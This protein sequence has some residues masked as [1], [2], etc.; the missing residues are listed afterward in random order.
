MSKFEIEMILYKFT[1]SY[2]LYIT[3]IKTITQHKNN[4]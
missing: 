1:E 4:L 2:T 3:T